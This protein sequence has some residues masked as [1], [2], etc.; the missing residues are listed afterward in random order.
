M[1]RPFCWGILS[2]A[3]IADTFV[4]AISSIPQTGVIAVAS[5]DQSRAYDWAAERAVPFA[6]GSYQDLLDS[7]QVDAVYIPLPNSLHAEWTLAAIEAGVPALCEKPFTANAAEAR[8][9]A[10]AAR[11]AKIPVAEAF[12]YRFHPIYE[13]VFELLESESI[14]EIKSLHASFSHTLDNP[15]AVQYRHD[16]AGG[17]LMDLGCYGVSF[18]RF[19]TGQEPRRVSAVDIRSDVDLSLHG[20]LQFENGVLAQIDCSLETSSR[21]RAEIVG[22]KGRIVLNAPWSPRMESATIL[23]ENNQSSERLEI[24]GANP[25]SLEILDFME[26]VQQQR[27]PRWPVEDA[28]RNMDVIDALYRS[29]RERRMIP[30]KTGKSKRSQ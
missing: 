25:Y 6:Y 10:N 8:Q 12:M 11:Q 5:R 15:S 3:N 19:I 14:G 9:V 17:A 24:P 13:K 23:V 22:T 16:L 18:T 29:A 27:D 20:I 4:K 7:N 26:A 2:T 30:I 1:A 28:I 21:T